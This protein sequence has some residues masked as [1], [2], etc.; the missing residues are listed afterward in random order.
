MVQALK[1]IRGIS[2]GLPTAKL[3]RY[4][5][6][7]KFPGKVVV[8]ASL[9][10]PSLIVLK[11]VADI[12]PSTPVVFCHPGHLFPESTEYRQKIIDL[13]GLTN[14]SATTGHETGVQR[15]DNDHFE[16]MWAESS[17]GSGRVFEIVHLNQT[18]EPYDCW[19]SAVYHCDRAEQVDRR[20]DVDG[21]LI[22]IDPLLDWSKDDVRKFMRANAIPFHPFAAHAKPD[23]E[24]EKVANLTTHHY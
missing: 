24:R 18:L 1:E 21:R 9:R 16:R 10:A 23:I 6:E 8:T 4:L 13:L 17:D 20:V 12:D 3:L 5:I 22:R 15:G 19:I 2:A 14:T 11:M 7:D